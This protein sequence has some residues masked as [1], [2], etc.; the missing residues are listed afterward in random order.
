MDPDTLAAFV[1]GVV[2]SGA[3]LLPATLGAIVTE[4]S[5]ATNL[6]VEGV[7]VFGA[8]AAYGVA[9]TTGDLVIGVLAASLLG[10][11]LCVTHA[12]PLVRIRVSM[13]Q[14]FVL[15]L[16][17]VFLGDALSRLF[18]QP[19]INQRTAAIDERWR[20]PLLSDIPYLGEALFQQRSLIY[21]AYLLAVV[22]W[23]VLYKTRL[24]LHLR[25][26]GEDPATADSMGVPVERYRFGAIVV[27]GMLMAFAG[28][29][30]SLSLI[31][32]WTEGLT[33]GRGWIALGLVTFANWHPLLAIVGTLIFGGFEAA[34]FRL[35]AAFP[36]AQYLLGI[37]PYLA[38]IVTLPLIAHRVNF[39]RG[40]APLA[41]GRPYFREERG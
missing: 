1:S 19:F 28:A 27:G 36:G 16:I 23:F 10:G 4:K 30:L 40:G 41:L 22:V 12:V 31:G 29:V 34:Q 11:L 6:G 20:V 24:G 26:V 14:Q 18:G 37:F 13:E 17:L 3:A 21:V 32:A 38:P 33:G 8:M 7:M 2:R 39:R 35:P 15:G 9:F 5:G 25:A